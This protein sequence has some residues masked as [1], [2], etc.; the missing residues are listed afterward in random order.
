AG[1]QYYESAALQCRARAYCAANFDFRPFGGGDYRVIGGNPGTIID[2]V[3]LV[4]LAAIPHG[5]DGTDVRAGNLL[6]GAAN[7]SDTVAY[8]DIL[9]QQT[10]RS[11]FANASYKISKDWQWGLSGS[12]SARDFKL[13][14]PQGT[15]NLPVPAT[16]AFNHLG[17]SV[18]VAYDP[19]SD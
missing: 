1:F 19:T 5:Q 17:K 3:T 8:N 9:P 6:P 14:T 15:A 7:Y 13:T 16:N 4:P 18:L 11:V 10:M 12:Y 2:A